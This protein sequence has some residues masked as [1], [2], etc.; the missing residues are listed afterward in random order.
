MRNR[1]LHDSLREFALEAAA[2]L[3]EDLKGGA[4]LEFEISDEGGRGGPALYVYRPLTLEFVAER[5]PRL[6]ELPSCAP[7]AD[8]LGDGAS[9]YLRV[10]GLGGEQAE[11]AL[12]AMLDRLYEDATSFGF[13]E[14]R[15]ERVYLEVERTLYKDTLP[16]T[17]VAPLHG[18]LLE[19]ERIDL[20]DGLSLARPGLSD[21][22]IDADA[23]CLLERDVP[24]DDPRPVEEAGERFARLLTALRL[25][26][27]GGPAL[28][29]VAWRRAGEGRWT[30]AELVTDGPGRGAPLVL[31]ADSGVELRELMAAIRPS[32][33]LTRFELGCARALAAEALS[34]YLLALRALLDATTEIGQASL[35]LRLAAL[36]AEDGER[37][38]LR[39]RVELALDLE[40]MVMRGGHTEVPSAIVD[41]M[42]RHLRALLKDVACGYLD[43]DL[44]SIADDI[45][46]ESGESIEIEARD[47]REHDTTEIEAIEPLVDEPG[48]EPEPEAESAAPWEPE[49][50]SAEAGEPEREEPEAWEPEPG[51]AEPWKPQ[52]DDA[53]QE[54]PARAEDGMP[55]GVTPSDDWGFSEDPDSYSAPV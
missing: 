51:K 2:L 36:C 12:Q 48:G 44:K 40:R 4:E 28:G 50:G 5:W 54:E 32:W 25:E 39:R 21:A 1:R 45:L 18:V 23:L 52:P 22:P 3:S 33:A 16:T 37:R 38:E 29:A 15:F 19:P 11:P 43:A 35:S 49:A 42:E 9:A 41:E 8:A 53:E 13:P 26:G 10:N 6:R 34:D 20:G 24:P 47:L 55:E 17:V 27:P 14:E 7:A 46:L 31:G 30:P